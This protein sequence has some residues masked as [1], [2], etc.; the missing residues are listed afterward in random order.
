MYTSCAQAHESCSCDVLI[1]SRF[2]AFL[3]NLA[4]MSSSPWSTLALTMR[5]SST[6]RSSAPTFTSPILCTETSQHSVL[7][8]M[9]DCAIQSR[10]DFH[11]A[12]DSS[13]DRVLPVEP[14]SRR[15]C[16]EELTA[17]K[18]KSESVYYLMHRCSLQSH[19]VRVWS[20]VGHA[21]DASTGVLQ[22]RANL[23]FELLAID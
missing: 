14:G 20:T 3:A 2:A 8:I 4:Q 22:V 9:L 12:L 11:S 5:T 23:V 21:Q 15:K 19:T 16:D 6:G 10:T 1:P 17:C 7:E 13:K 18:A